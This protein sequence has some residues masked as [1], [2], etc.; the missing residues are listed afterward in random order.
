MLSN[1]QVKNRSQIVRQYFHIFH[2]KR[3]KEGRKENGSGGGE[4]EKEEWKE[5]REKLRTLPPLG[6]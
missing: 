3:R 2:K 1:V 4:G 5:K 6:A